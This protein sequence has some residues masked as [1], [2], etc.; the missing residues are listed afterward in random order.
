MFDR[1]KVVLFSEINSK[2]GSPF[3]R[4]LS[5]HPLIK[6]IAVVT[7][8]ENVLCSYFVNDDTKVDIEIEAKALG[9][10]VLR[11]VRV[12]A[13]GV[14][15]E[16][17]KLEPDY[18][19]VANFQQL[20][21]SEL[22][23]I[24]RIAAINFHPAPLP[25]YAGL[26]P[27]FWMVRN[28]ERQSAISV[29]KMDEGLDTG[30]IIMQRQIPLTSQETSISLR[31]FQEKQNV[32]MLLD[33]IPLLATG[34]FTCVP[35]D[36]SKRTYYGRPQEQ[37]YLL[38]FSLDA[39][40]LQCHIRA[41][42]RHPGAHFFLPD[43]TKVVVLSATVP[44]GTDIGVPDFPGCI[45]QTAASIFIATADGWLQLL[46]IDVNGVESPV[47]PTSI[48][49][50]FRLAR[51]TTIGDEQALDMQDQMVISN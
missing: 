29:I 40:T 47:T 28:G 36:L 19:I 31:T 8:P 3:L 9:I 5:A 32:L 35:Q 51:Q 2:L 30:P 7:S 42:Y 41:G 23:A 34:A 49:E 24:P 1:L 22:L 4:V 26:A 21:S 18:L 37:D 14:A 10:K 20:L 6:L 16:L 13:P 15:G 43:G 17:A 39:K 12:N 44:H 50:I 33:L 38:D 45:V 25:C 11:P 27:F 48:P 46:T